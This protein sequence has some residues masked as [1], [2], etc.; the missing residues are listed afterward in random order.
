MWP[1]RHIEEGTLE[2]EELSSLP[3]PVAPRMKW[4]LGFWCCRCVDLFLVLLTIAWS[5]IELAWSLYRK[6]RKR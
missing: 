6:T 5:R 1:D 2:P 4:L 3:R